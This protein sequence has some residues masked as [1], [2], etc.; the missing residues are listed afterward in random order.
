[1]LHYK[2]L[3]ENRI[4]LSLLT[5]IWLLFLPNAPYLFTN[6]VHLG[7]NTTVQYI[8][9]FLLI[10]AFAIL[11]IYAELISVVELLKIWKPKINRAVLQ[12]LTFV[13]FCLCGYSLYWGRILR[14]NSWDVLTNPLILIQDVWYFVINPLANWPIL[15][16]SIILGLVLILIY[17]ALKQLIELNT[18]ETN[19]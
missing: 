11:A 14:Y 13:I 17:T 4:P 7:M 12:I 6:F 15:V 5:F 1:M 2:S 10:L 3:L 19:S 8:F 9:D 16:V 18:D